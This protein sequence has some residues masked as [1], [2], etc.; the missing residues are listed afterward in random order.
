VLRFS[1]EVPPGAAGR[2]VLCAELALGERRFGQIA[3]A[4]VDVT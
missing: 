3:E 4:L 1:V 2:H